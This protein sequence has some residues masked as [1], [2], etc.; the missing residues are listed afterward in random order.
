MELISRKSIDEIWLRIGQSTVT[1]LTAIH[2]NFK[3]EQPHIYRFIN[4]FNEHLDDEVSELILNYSL[5]IVLI[6]NVSMNKFKF[7]K[8]LIL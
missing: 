7:L 5:I 4:K 6:F 2:E 1:E 8:I 3:A